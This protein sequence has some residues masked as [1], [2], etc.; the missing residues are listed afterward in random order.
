MLRRGDAGILNVASTAGFQPLPYFAVYAASKSF[1]LNL[2]E[3]L[4][5]EY[6]GR[7]VTVT[8][9]SPGTTKT[10]FQARAGVTATLLRG[11]ETPEKVARVGLEALLDGKMSA[12]SGWGNHVKATLGRLV[13]DRGVVAVMRR[14]MNT[15]LKARAK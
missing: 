2:S 14:V 3:A 11:M 4:Y 15:A 8:C 1:V 10:G 6:A 5:G 13:P 12:V 9:L 7:G